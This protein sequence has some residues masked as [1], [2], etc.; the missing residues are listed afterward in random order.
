MERRITMIVQ[1]TVSQNPDTIIFGAFGC[2]EFGN[3]REVVYPM[4]EKTINHYVPDHIRILFADPKAAGS[5][6][7]DL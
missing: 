5:C 2:G 6:M 3:K 7:E 1:L 4:F